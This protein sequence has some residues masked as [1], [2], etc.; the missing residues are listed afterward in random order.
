MS[1]ASKVWS[2]G[3][4]V[5]MVVALRGADARTT[6][7]VLPQLRHGVLAQVAA[8]DSSA[9]RDAALSPDQML[10]EVNSYFPQMDQ[11]ASTVRRQLS[12]AREQRD[13]VKVLCL[14]DK[15]TQINVAVR[16][17]QDRGTSLRAA[18]SRNDKERSRH[19]FTVLRVLRDRVRT[20]VSE[21][22]QCI[23]EEVGFVGESK[24]TANI[25]PNIPAV[26]PTEVPGDNTIV[27]TPPVTSS[28]VQ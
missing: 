25:D 23:G 2:L 24:V 9:S 4:G 13:V 6:A 11:G 27:S 12:S 7:D 3:F 28:P 14:N 10:S 20:L 21:S 26:D 1:K 15:L 16:S 19:E 17:A 18:V 5:A 8:V 22:N